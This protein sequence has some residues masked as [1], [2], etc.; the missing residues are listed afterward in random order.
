MVWPWRAGLVYRFNGSDV[1]DSKFC[2]IAMP[3][4]CE[5]RVNIPKLFST[6]WN[7]AAALVV[8]PTVTVI[9]AAPAGTAEGRTALIC[10][11]LT[12]CRKA[13]YVAGPLLDLTVT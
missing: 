2:A 12:K 8:V 3:A 5:L 1:G 7:G 4:G 6:T 13:L 11:G 10:P 9:V